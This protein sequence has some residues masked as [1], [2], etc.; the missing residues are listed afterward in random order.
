LPEIPEEKSSSHRKKSAGGFFS[1]IITTGMTLNLTGIHLILSEIYPV[2]SGTNTIGS[3]MIVK[4]S[5]INTV[6]NGMK[7]GLTGICHFLQKPRLNPTEN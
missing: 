5:Q 1:E 2:R 6:W 4:R 7:A 3:G